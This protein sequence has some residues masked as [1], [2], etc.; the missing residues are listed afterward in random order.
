[1]KGFSNYL[2][3]GLLA[4]AMIVACS[5]AGAQAFGL[6]VVPSANSLL[7]SNSLTYTINATN[8]TGVGLV[9]VWI[10]NSFSAPFQYITSTASQLVGATNTTTNVLFELGPVGV[11]GIVQVLLTVQPNAV[12]AFTNSVV[13]AVPGTIYVTSTNAVVNATNV[14]V[15][16]DLG[17]TMTGPLQT[18][19]TNDLM[20][21]GVTVTNL[22][23]NDAPNVILT[24]TLPPG[25]IPISPAN[26]TTFSLGTLTN[27]GSASFLFTV[28]PTNAGV[29]PF[30][31]S[32]GSPTVQDANITNNTATTNITVLNYLSGPLAVTTNSPETY[33]PQNGLVE[34]SI[35]VTNND[36]NNAAAVRVVVAGL[37]NRLFNAVGTNSGNPFVVYSAALNTNQSV[38][39]LLQY[40]ASAY[41]TFTNGQLRAFAVPSSDWTPP[42]A[43]GTSTNLDISRIVELTNGN[44]LIEWPTTPGKTY[45]VIYSD[46]VSF[47]NATIAPPPI[48]AP[49]N[50]TQWIDYGP[51]ATRSVPT[52]AAR[53]YRV[54]QNP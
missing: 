38:N 18:V 48:V 10:T 5:R 42:S 6:S 8:L 16:S 29:L 26:Q 12:G 9:D 4:L 19:I 30:T 23:P 7:V 36:T 2:K 51:P 54:F 33:N 22:G 11:G 50:R 37:T 1:M 46:N 41:F 13:V 17:V 21:Y 3:S 49:A 45:T 39:L 24:N 34:Q 25:V 47:S 35:T 44:M 14:T 52:N 31:A 53:F 28:E 27:G 40:S 15:L 43:T 20:T 32:V